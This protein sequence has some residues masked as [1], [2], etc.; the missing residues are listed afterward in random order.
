ME[1]K[2]I[3]V[4][5]NA[6]GVEVV[7]ERVSGELAGTSKVYLDFCNSEYVG[8]VSRRPLNKRSSERFVHLFSEKI[9]FSRDKYAVLRVRWYEYVR[10]VVKSWEARNLVHDSCKDG[11]IV[12]SMVSC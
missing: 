12:R 9:K 7:L 1:I 2:K 8:A 5:G 3:C 4:S 10:E 6:L 11:D